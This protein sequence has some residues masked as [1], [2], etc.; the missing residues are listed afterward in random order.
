MSVERD[1]ITKANYE[2]AQ[3]EMRAGKTE[4]QVRMAL[5]A[6][7]VDYQSA[8]A[9]AAKLFGSQTRGSPEHE[10]GTRMM[11]QGALLC[12]GGCVVTA[13]TYSMASKAGG[14]YVITWGAIVFG[15]IRF[16]RGLAM[17]DS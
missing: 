7:G 17:R 10:A 4:P 15:A 16:F 11:L 8:R 3:R 2:L 13:V 9:V 12:I 6:E 1:R 5:I 14:S